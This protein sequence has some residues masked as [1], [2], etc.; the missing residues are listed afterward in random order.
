MFYLEVME[1]FIVIWKFIKI[2]FFYFLKFIFNINVLKQ[3]KNMKNI[4]L[5]IIQK[6]SDSQFKILISNTLLK[7][8]RSMNK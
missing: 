5:K 8:R 1:C 3:Y 4:N 7:L 6:F 2:I